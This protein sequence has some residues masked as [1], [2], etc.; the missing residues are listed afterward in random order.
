[1]KIAGKRRS[2]VYADISWQLGIASYH[3]S[4]ATANNWGIQVNNLRKS[5]NTGISTTGAVYRDG[6]IGDFTQCLLEFI[7]DGDCTCA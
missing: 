3:P 2:P 5:M 7:L 1:M 6:R 4:L